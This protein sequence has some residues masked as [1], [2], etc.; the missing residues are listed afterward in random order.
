MLGFVGVTAV[1]VQAEHIMMPG[2]LFG[3]EVAGGIQYRLRR[4]A[5]GHGQND[6]QG[7]FMFALFGNAEFA[8][9]FYKIPD[10]AFA[11]QFFAG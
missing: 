11:D 8:P 1:V 2:E 7:F 9:I 3:G 6:I 10:R 4:R 5:F